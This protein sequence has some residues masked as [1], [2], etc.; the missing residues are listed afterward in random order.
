MIYKSILCSLGSDDLA[1]W[2]P[3]LNPRSRIGQNA[4][5]LF[6]RKVAHCQALG[7]PRRQHL[8]AGEGLKAAHDSGCEHLRTWGGCNIIILSEW[9]HLELS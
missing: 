2:T 7:L 8:L 4:I 1:E 6:G 9:G 3:K 5:Q